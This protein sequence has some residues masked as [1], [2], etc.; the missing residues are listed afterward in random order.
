MPKRRDLIRRIAKEARQQGIPFSVLR[1]GARHT[2]FEVGGVRVP[3]PRHDEINEMTAESIYKEA[4][5]VLG[6]EWWR[7]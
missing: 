6:R 4:A 3:V 1:E 7:T 5:E 2:I